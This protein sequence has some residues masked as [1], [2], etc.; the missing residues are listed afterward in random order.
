MSKKV[1]V[2]GSNSFSG[3]YVIKKF[4]E[5]GYEVFGVSRSAE[6]DELFLRYRFGDV[7]TG[8]FKFTQI[9]INT[10]FVSLNKLINE[11][12]PSTIINFAAQGMVAES[13]VNPLDWFQT[14]VM[15]QIKLA[16][17]LKNVDYLDRFI[18]FTTP[19]VYGS[20]SGWISEDTPFEPSTPYATSR[21]AFDM[22]LKNIFKAFGFPVLF[23]RAANVY[24][25]G[26]QIYRIIPRAMLSCVLNERFPLHGGGSSERAFIHMKDVADAVFKVSKEGLVGET[27]HVSTDD[28]MTILKLVE[29]IGNHYGKELNDFVDIVDERLGKDHAYKLSSKK[30]NTD[31]GWFP[32]IALAEGIDEM[33]GWIRKNLETLKGIER[34]Y[35]HKK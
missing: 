11:F 22:H 23:T 1:L 27:Y 15:A 3:S 21:A 24:G 25:A 31:L 17:F 9:D 13:W 5:N 16:E 32:T 28:A 14:N 35:R 4:L 33:D 8:K 2:I 10:D 12:K 20:T 7:K 34:E 19:E 18:Q 29:T 6:Y 30:L 26:Q